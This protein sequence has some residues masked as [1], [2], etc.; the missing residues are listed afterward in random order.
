MVW[1]IAVGVALGSAVAAICA[2]ASRRYTVR[3]VRGTYFAIRPEG[4]TCKLRI[5]GDLDYAL[6]CERI[7][8]LSGRA[9]LQGG[10]LYMSG[11]I[12]D[13]SASEQ[14][15]ISELYQ[16]LFTAEIPPESASN[17]T[18]K[19][20]QVLEVMS[21]GQRTYLVSPDEAGGFCGAIADGREPRTHLFGRFF[22]R[23]GDEKYA[24][25]SGE[26]PEVCHVFED[27]LRR[28]K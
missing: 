6:E 10:R 21:L 3:S 24:T 25:R 2:T 16:R 14:S 17:P 5:G 20:A 12:E 26:V 4:G 22:L 23:S 27:A 11:G 8:R 7:P 15:R 9:V 13:L 1:K 28:S 19:P 18:A